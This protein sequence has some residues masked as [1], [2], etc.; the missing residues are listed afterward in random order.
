MEKL[1]NNGQCEAVS[2]GV[3]IQGRLTLLL[4][5]PQSKPRKGK[6]SKELVCPSA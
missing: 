4:F 6:D 3:D 2:R 5:F 1:R